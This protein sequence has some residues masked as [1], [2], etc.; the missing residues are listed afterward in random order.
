MVPTYN[1]LG[2]RY[3]GGEG[4]SFVPRGARVG[5]WPPNIRRVLSP[6]PRGLRLCYRDDR[7]TIQGNTHSALKEFSILSVLHILK[8]YSIWHNISC[9]LH[10]SGDKIWGESI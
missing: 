6:S 2:P 9:H 5:L 3:S 10:K 1:I 4:P 7:D 8:V